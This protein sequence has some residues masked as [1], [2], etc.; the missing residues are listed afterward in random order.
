MSAAVVVLLC[1]TDRQS[2][3]KSYGLKRP[4]GGLIL[5]SVPG[6]IYCVR[7]EQNI[8]DEVKQKIFRF[9]RCSAHFMFR[10]PKTRGDAE[11]GSQLYFNLG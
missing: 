8:P 7:G 6:T 10:K 1:Q 11:L 2:K 3:G 4:T 9:L 5:K